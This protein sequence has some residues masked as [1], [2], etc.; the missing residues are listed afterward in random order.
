MGVAA[1]ALDASQ[2]GPFHGF[3][4]QGFV[5]FRVRRLCGAQ[6]RGDDA[7]G[8][9]EGP[10]Q[11]RRRRFLH[12]KRKLRAVISKLD[13]G[14]SAQFGVGDLLAV[15]VG[16]VGAAG[17][18]NS[19]VVAVL[20]DLYVLRGNG[21]RAGALNDDLV[22]RASADT[23]APIGK[24]VTGTGKRPRP[25]NEPRFGPGS[26]YAIVSHEGTGSFTYDF[27]PGR[28]VGESPPGGVIH[29]T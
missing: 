8:D 23:R 1:Q 11:F 3:R 10:L 16:S 22:L 4:K 9:D 19:P 26:H 29:D 5:T 20:G 15:E 2:A 24:Q 25:R 21:G 13:D 6:L 27:T 18:A 14:L 12:Q 17:V 7:P 28:P